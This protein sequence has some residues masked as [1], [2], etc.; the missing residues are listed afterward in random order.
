M[1]RYQESLKDASPLPWATTCPWHTKA[2]TGG[3]QLALRVL[4]HKLL[5][6][7]PPTGR[8][9]TSLASSEA[10]RGS[11]LRAK[12][13]QTQGTGGWVA[14]IPGGRWGKRRGRQLAATKNSM[15]LK[16]S[17]A[18]ASPLRAELCLAC[19]ASAESASVISLGASHGT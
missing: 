10:L 15:G 4:A 13:G 8:R 14:L 3:A 6:V 1:Q 12:L 17:F 18:V 7:A 16:S 5:Q 2:G 19:I 11:G 9:R